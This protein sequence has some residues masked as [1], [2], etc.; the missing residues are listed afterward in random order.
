MRT[1][2]IALSFACHL[3]I[4]SLSWAAS[5]SIETVSP[6]IGQRGTE[7]QLKLI[8]AGLSDAAEVMLYSPGVTCLALKPTS[9]NELQVHLRATAD[10]PLG[11]HA[12]RVRTTKGISELRT[13]RVTPLPV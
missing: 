4:V 1:R 6:G 10:C 13:F 7:F 2:W 11:T 8:G 12:F 5:P 9:D 3:S